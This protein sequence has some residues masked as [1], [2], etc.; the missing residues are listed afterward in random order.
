[1]LP[2]TISAPDYQRKHHLKT[3]T[4]I[5]YVPHPRKTQSQNSLSALSSIRP[6]SILPS[7]APKTGSLPRQVG[8]LLPRFQTLIFVHGCFWHAHTGCKNFRLPNTH[9]KWWKKKNFGNAEHDQRKQLKLKQ[10]N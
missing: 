3:T 1:M 2:K 6:G 7:I 9:T 10:F 8:Y 4:I 5:Q